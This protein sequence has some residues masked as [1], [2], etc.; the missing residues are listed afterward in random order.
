MARLHFFLVLFL[1]LIISAAAH[2]GDDDGDADSDS[3]LSEQSDKPH[4]RSRPLVLVKIWCLIIV[5]FGTFIGGVSPYFMK[6][7]EGFLVLGTQFA[8]GVFLG[9]ALMHF[10]SDAN[11]TSSGRPGRYPFAYMLACAGYLMTMLADCV[12][13]F[14]YAKQSNSNN[15]NDVQLQGD[16]EN[17]KSN[18]TVAQ[19]QSQVSDGREND[20]SK[21]PLATA[22][23]LGDSILL[24]VALCFH[25]VF[26][27]IAIGVADSQADA[28]R[29][30][31]TVSL[32]KIF[33]AIAMGIALLRMIPNRPLLSCAAYAFAFAISSPIGV[34]IGI[35]IDAT[36]QGV[37]A[38]WIFAIS[39][40]LACGVF[41]FVSINHLLSKGY[42]PQKMVSIDKSHFKFLAVLLGVGI[43][44]V[45]MIWDT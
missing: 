45:V 39:M 35:I 36:T 16:T 23:S 32:H 44:A 1:L 22:S 30:L 31:W 19:G 6:W 37:V 15:N 2:G 25:S 34:A 7:N 41:I 4:L 20:Y 18:G 28:W 10:L 3:G 38:D 42:K 33:A 21:A 9:T 13:C 24:I 11:E 8:G 29:A 43:I 12:I 14:V 27:G 26:E 5:F 17:G 40:G